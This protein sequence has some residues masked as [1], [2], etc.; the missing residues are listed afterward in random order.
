MAGLET[1]FDATDVAKFLQLVQRH[2]DPGGEC[3]RHGLLGFT[4][5]GDRAGGVA[6]QESN[7]APALCLTAQ[8][9]G[10]VRLLQPQEVLKD[11]AALISVLIEGQAVAVVGTAL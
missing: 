6:E 10:Q 2:C 11:V 9:T 1:A 5:C 4:R 7:A 3:Q 8:C